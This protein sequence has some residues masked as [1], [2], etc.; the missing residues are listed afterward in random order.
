MLERFWLKARIPSLVS[1]AF[2]TMGLLLSP[3][4]LVVVL[5]V[6]FCGPLIGKTQLVKQNFV[7]KLK[8]NDW[9]KI[10]LVLTLLILAFN[11]QEGIV[12]FIFALIPI[13]WVAF[14]DPS[15]FR[16][17]FK[18]TTTLNNINSEVEKEIIYL[19]DF[20][21]EGK[22]GE[23]KEEN[24]NSSK[25][26]LNEK[27]EEALIKVISNNVENYD[28]KN[29]EEISDDFVS[30]VKTFDF[31][32]PEGS[33]DSTLYEWIHLF[34]KKSDLYKYFLNEKQLSAANS[35]PSGYIYGP[36]YEDDENKEELQE[37]ID[38]LHFKGFFVVAKEAIRLNFNFDEILGYFK[39]YG[40]DEY[41]DEI[42]SLRVES[43]N[44]GSSNFENPKNNWKTLDED[45]ILEKIKTE[46]IPVEVF[47]D[48][49]NSENYSIR[50]ALALNVQ[51]PKN[52]LNILSKDEDNDVKDAVAYRELPQEWK[53][54]DDYEKIDKLKEEED[55]DLSV[56]KILANSNNYSLRAAVAI[57]PST[58]KEILEKL[59]KDDDDSVKDAIAYRELPQEWKS[60][61]DNEKI[62]KLKEEEEV[63]LAVIKILANSSDYSLR[64]AV[65]IHPSTPKEILEKLADDE[66]D[67]V[68][69]ALAYRE[70][71]QKWKSIDDYEKIEKLEEE[72][73]VDLAVIKIFA[74]SNNYSLRAAVA[75][76]PSTPKEILE[77]LADD[78]YEDVKE[79]V[80]K[81]LSKKGVL[82][83]RKQVSPKNIYIKTE[84]A[85]K[86]IFGE[87]NTDQIMKLNKSISEK[88][89]NEELLELKYNSDD[90][91]EGVFSYGNDGE[92]GNEGII[93]FDDK[94]SIELPQ[95][96]SGKYKDGIYFCHLSL[97]KASIEFSFKTSDGLEFD[98]YEFKE[99]SVPV[100]LPR[101]FT[102][103]H[104]L[105]G[106]DINEGF[107][108]VTD[109][110]Y[111][112]QILEEYDNE[113]ID[114][115]YDD[116]FRIIE[117]KNGKSSIIYSNYNGE[118]NWIEKIEGTKEIENTFKKNKEKKEVLTTEIKLDNTLGLYKGI[119][120]LNLPTI[121]A[122]RRTRNK[123]DMKTEISRAL[124]DIISEIID[125]ESQ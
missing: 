11:G 108:I 16:N 48:L 39:N 28:I 54:I 73:E 30:K 66:Y 23:D 103:G 118:E 116:L 52:I 113:L 71:P 4:T 26:D 95:I 100:N 89:L 83:N 99:I 109:F 110:E 80:I 17:D 72:E 37:Q 86:V 111:K 34:L 20:E 67:D 61:D 40:M 115:G 123:D 12:F 70:L 53:S 46:E 56:I 112:G 6:A 31:S 38:N 5:L 1:L 59:S 88:T 36:N 50:Q 35:V 29:F 92:D 13:V 2:L 32:R 63:D 47:D 8:K 104:E 77:K 124:S 42:N 76:H 122:T 78:E 117:Y 9:K 125:K 69:D 75:I 94:S 79:N 81:N 60:V 14:K 82:G 7:S 58:P 91:Y 114:R 18:D 101:I 62:E 15:I 65:A 102:E 24:G 19:N 97:T 49:V 120:T 22:E 90:I 3:W 51:T 64:A 121:K 105:Y 57:H 96:D 44:N 33:Y 45:E 74:N 55:V 10:A 27:I 93:K 84:P 21:E 41:V 107:N 87:L 25:I 119:A 98:P 106:S 68:K 43:S 85:G